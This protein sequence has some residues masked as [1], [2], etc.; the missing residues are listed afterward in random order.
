MDD[1][2][3]NKNTTT[4][5]DEL[6]S[7]R[8]ILRSD[9]HLQIQPSGDYEQVRVK[10]DYDIQ[11]SFFFDSLNTLNKS[12]TI[13]NVHDLRIIKSSNKCPLNNDQWTNIRQYFDELIQK[14][15]ESISLESIIQLIQDH[16]L[17]LTIANEKSKQKDKNSTE[18]IST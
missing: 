12:L 18:N 11:I 10:L 5:T 1:N 6:N 3:N 9:D 8:S 14:S 4:I 13:N 16:L 15:T 7:L 17:K 2:D